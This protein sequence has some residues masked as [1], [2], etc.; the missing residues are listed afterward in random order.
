M[1]G[2][3]IEQFNFRN[4]DIMK[5]SFDTETYLNNK[6][7]FLD[8]Y[9]A[10]LLKYHK[11]YS[12]AF[13]N[14][15]NPYW[16]QYAKTIDDLGQSP[17]IEEQLFCVN[18]DITP[19]RPYK[20]P[21]IYKIYHGIASY[22]IPKKMTFLFVFTAINVPIWLM[23]LSFLLPISRQKKRIINYNTAI[24]VYADFLVWPCCEHKIYYSSVF[25]V[26][27]I[28]IYFN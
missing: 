15:N 6:S 14:L 9:F 19:V 23:L 16:Y 4:A 21:I 8:N 25:H 22:E 27:F 13:L 10:L 28:F 24:V 17:Y 2:G 20:L 5:A 12:V 18:D 26:S 11:D 3:N 1:P 7:D